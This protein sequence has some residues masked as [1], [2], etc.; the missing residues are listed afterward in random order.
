MAERN[1]ALGLRTPLRKLTDDEV[2]LIYKEIDRINADRS[3]FSINKDLI[4]KTKYLED[5]DMI[6]IGSN[7][8][9]DLENGTC[10]RDRMPIVCVLAHE[11]YGHRAQLSK[12]RKEAEN[13]VNTSNTWEDEYNA[14]YLATMNTPNLTKEER[15]MLIEDAL[16]RKREANVKV[17]YDDFIKEVLDMKD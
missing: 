17:V 4:I 16:D 6:V 11:Y 14:S 12:Y 15:R 1:F 9:P 7:V 5:R 13:G 10:A 2:E 3:K 8:I